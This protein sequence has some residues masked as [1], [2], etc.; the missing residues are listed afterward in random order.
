MNFKIII[1]EEAKSDV[2]ESITWYKNIN[3]IFSKRFTNSF[4]NSVKQ[5]KENPYQYQIRYD[6]VR[7]VLLRTFPYLIHF[8]I[9]NE[10]IVIKA[11]FH[12]SRDSK[13]NKLF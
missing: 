7:V 11:V 2:R 12:T 8:S 13:I 9:D 6:E 5:I 10:T 4:S 3:P 1:L